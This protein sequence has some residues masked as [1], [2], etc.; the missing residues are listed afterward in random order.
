MHPR[1]RNGARETSATPPCTHTADQISDTC[2]TLSTCTP[3]SLHHMPATCTPA[4]LATGRPAPQ[5]RASDSTAGHHGRP[6]GGGGR[7]EL[8]A[9]RHGGLAGGERRRVPRHWGAPAQLPACDQPIA[10]Q[11][12]SGIPAVTPQAKVTG[13]PCTFLQ[14][15]GHRCAK[16]LLACA[17]MSGRKHCAKPHKTT[18]E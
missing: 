14:A 6:G 13:M 16:Y 11:T 5:L 8:R 1:M 4:A 15:R 17:V 2:I 18:D 12:A 9:R 10:V 7:G 3:G